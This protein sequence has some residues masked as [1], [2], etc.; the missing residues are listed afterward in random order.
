MVAIGFSLIGITL[1]SLF[2]WWRGK[3]F[4]SL[5]WLKILVISVLLPQIGN[6]VGWYTAE[7]GRQPWIVYGLLKTSDGLSK[8]VKSEHI[9]F[10][11]V[12][13][14]L[15]YAG[16]FVV[17]LYLLDKKIKHGPDEK[18]RGLD[19]SENLRLTE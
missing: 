17:F 1:I 15:I 19:F 10:S 18:T 11:L 8:T 4:N 14:T 2:L 9:I 7:I 12:L 13:F 6:Q 5:L 3:L 16:L